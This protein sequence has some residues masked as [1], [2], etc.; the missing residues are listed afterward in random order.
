MKSF[1][2][3]AVLAAASQALLNFDDLPDIDLDQF[4]EN[5]FDNL[6]DHFNFL[7]DRTYK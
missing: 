3:A 7:D 2:V 4:E 6:I 1:T 5:T